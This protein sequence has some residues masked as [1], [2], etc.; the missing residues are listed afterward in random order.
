MAAVHLQ[1]GSVGEAALVPGVAASA[2]AATVTLRVCD[3]AG[4]DFATVGA[5][6][7]HVASAYAAGTVTLALDEGRT[8]TES[9]GLQQLAAMPPSPGLRVVVQ[10]AG[11]T[12]RLVVSDTPQ[13]SLGVLAMPGGYLEFANLTMEGAGTLTIGA[14]IGAAARA[15][16]RD[17]EFD[18]INTL[19]R[20]FEAGSTVELRTVTSDC[21]QVAYAFQGG[22]ALVRDSSFT[23]NGAGAGVPFLNAETGGVIV[24]VAT[25]NYFSFPTLPVASSGA[26][27]TTGG[28]LNT[29]GGGSP[30]CSTGGTVIAADGSCFPS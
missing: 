2:A 24:H 3:G 21:Q 25:V 13:T 11:A 23:Y 20:A 10:G 9:A 29:A 22:V 15:V 17:M 6:F 16:F 12:T 8:Y 27:I 26:V 5:A 4:C 7:S 28:G 18:N 1:N 14:S 19:V 30:T